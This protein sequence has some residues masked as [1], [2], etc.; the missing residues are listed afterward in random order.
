MAASYAVLYTETPPGAK[1]DRPAVGAAG[2]SIGQRPGVC[3]A[4][5]DNRM[6]PQIRE[7]RNP[8]TREGVS[9]P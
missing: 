8:Q 3:T 2:R 1:R 7:K 5:S 6:I 4:L 9:F